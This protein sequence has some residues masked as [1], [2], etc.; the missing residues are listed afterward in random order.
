MVSALEG[1]PH[2]LLVVLGCDGLP[3][4]FKVKGWTTKRILKEAFKDKIPSEVI[5]R[6]K[7]GLPVPLRRW[8]RDDL[9]DFVRE[10]LLSGRSISRGYFQKNAIE[11]LLQRN[12]VDGALM[13]EVF[14]LLTLELWHREFIDV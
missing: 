9:A 8:M 5:E 6:R 7:T 12:A 10:V 2:L 14:S 13:K 3:A 11:R 1:V 4:H